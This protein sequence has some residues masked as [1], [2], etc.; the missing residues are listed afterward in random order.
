MPGRGSGTARTKS[1]ASSKRGWQRSSTAPATGLIQLCDA[2][3]LP[4]GFCLI[5]KRLVDVALRH[6]TN[7]YTIPKWKAFLEIQREFEETIGGSIYALLP[8]VIENTFG[9]DS[10]AS[11]ASSGAP[12]GPRTSDAAR[13]SS[14]L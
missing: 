9:F 11:S 1:C 13:K 3:A 12:N 5:E 8:G 10:S 2:L 14:V 6:G 7:P 4:G